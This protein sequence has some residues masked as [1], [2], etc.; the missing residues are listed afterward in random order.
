M[1]STEPSDINALFAPYSTI[2]LDIMKREIYR[3]YFLLPIKK[4]FKLLRHILFF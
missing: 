1:V 2:L 3:G 4:K